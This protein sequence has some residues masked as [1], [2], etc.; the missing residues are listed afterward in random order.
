MAPGVGTGMSYVIFLRDILTGGAVTGDPSHRFS[1]L[2]ADFRENSLAVTAA[3]VA[4]SGNGDGGLKTGDPVSP[5]IF[6]EFLLF[7]YSAGRARGQSFSSLS[8]P[9]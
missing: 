7:F 2:S 8:A 3:T 4:P 1:T 6:V 9:G 5:E